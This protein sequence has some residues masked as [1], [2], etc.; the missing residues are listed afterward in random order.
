M[1]L[2]KH[3]LFHHLGKEF[4]HQ[5]DKNILLLRIGPITLLMLGDKT[6]AKTSWVSG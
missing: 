4:C 3:F 2:S 1:K 6:A 5:S